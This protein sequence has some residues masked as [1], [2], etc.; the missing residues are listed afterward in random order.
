MDVWHV[1]CSKCGYE[2]KLN[3]GSTDLD[4]TYS[5]LNEDFAYY[6]LFTCKIENIFVTANVHNRQ[7]DNKCPADGSLLIPEEIPPKKCPK[8]KADITPSKLDINVILGE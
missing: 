2:I 6:K 8:C 3:L 4:Q 1:K 7:F 5:D